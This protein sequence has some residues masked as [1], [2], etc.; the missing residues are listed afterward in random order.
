MF[1]ACIILTLFCTHDSSIIGMRASRGV[2]VVNTVSKRWLLSCTHQSCAIDGTS[3]PG[4]GT[5]EGGVSTY[6]KASRLKLTKCIIL[7]TIVI[8]TACM[9]ACLHI[10]TCESD[11]YNKTDLFQ[12]T[13]TNSRNYLDNDYNCSI[14]MLIWRHSITNCLLTVSRVAELF[15]G[16]LCFLR[17]PQSITDSTPGLQTTD[18]NS[19]LAWPGASD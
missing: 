14:I 10:Y 7:H 1:I 9:Y 8:R 17:A 2:H 4:K 5:T 16:H 3:T 6:T 11:K 19:S 15:A 18:L 13:I 12:R